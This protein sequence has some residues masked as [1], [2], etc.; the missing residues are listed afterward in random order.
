MLGV[1]MGLNMS[2]GHLISITYL[3][4]SISKES[5]QF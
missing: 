4:G 1:G 5:L 2:L 3:Q